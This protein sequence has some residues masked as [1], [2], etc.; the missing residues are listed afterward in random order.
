MKLKKRLS[1]L[2]LGLSMSC[3]TLQASATVIKSAD[4]HP[5]GY[6]NV[7]AIQHM[8]EK[9]K[10]ATNGKLE[11]KVYS[12]G[13]LGDET[14]SF[15][16][17]QLG[18]IDM[19]RTSMSI[20]ST[21]IPDV[22]V[23]NLPYVFN[24]VEHMHRV[25]DGDIGQELANKI[26]NSKA[27]VVFL[28]W[29]DSGIR[30]LITTEP[31]RSFDDLKGVKIRV[32]GNP[33]AIESLNAMGANAVSMGTGEVFSAMQTGVIDGA[34]NNEP[35]FVSQNYAA[36]AKFYPLSK[37]FMI[38]EAFLYSKVKWDKLT[39]DEQALI[40]KLAKE[41]QDEQRVLW[42]EYTEASVEQMKKDGVEI[43]ELDTKPFVEA[44][45]SVRDKFGKGHEE[46][47]KRINALK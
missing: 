30:N 11:I 43:I 34:E 18:A 7:V 24:D 4:I 36:A 9:L 3:F 26:N 45:Q 17:L 16:Q 44:T 15:Q 42:K 35:T 32:Q 10:E 21:V 27:K 28:G 47:I 12:G 1:S 40:L 20:V 46:L 19:V 25:L 6:P 2:V 39:K 5:E 29:M 14:K 8:G 13:V 38:P 31:V 33:V 23:F 41:A 22:N 37:H